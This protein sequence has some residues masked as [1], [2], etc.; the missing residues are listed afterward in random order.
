MESKKPWTSR[1]IV[2]NAVMGI[3]ASVALFVPQA[4]SAADFL[5]AH[6]EGVILAWSVLNIVLRTVTSGKV[7]LTD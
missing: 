7:S 1:T 4:K 5:T 6:S 3:L 2:I